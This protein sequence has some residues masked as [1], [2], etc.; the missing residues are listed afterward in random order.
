MAGPGTLYQ[1]GDHASR[2]AVGSGC[3]LYSCTTHGLVYR[4][5]GTSWTTF[6]TLPG[7][8]VAAADV[9]FDATGLTNT[10]ATDVQEAIADLDGA[11]VTAGGVPEE[12]AVV[13]HSGGTNVSTS[14]VGAANRALIV[15]VTILVATEITG[16][17]IRVASGG[18][19]GNV[20]VGIY[21]SSL[22]RVAT[23]GSVATPATGLATV[24]LTANYSAAAGRYYFGLSCSSNTPQFVV[25]SAAATA[26]PLHS[27]FME[28]AHPLPDP[29]VSA[30]ASPV[31]PAIVGLV[32]GGWAP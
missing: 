2:P 13:P 15:P 21:N 27:F 3:V 4:D 30:G 18:G 6:L 10:A 24:S 9:S 29:F 31:V 17:R 11:I 5:D 22:V 14:V 19:T 23:S 16:M 8:A 26:G 1:T 28:T 20:S 7:G 25:T 12:W 32:T